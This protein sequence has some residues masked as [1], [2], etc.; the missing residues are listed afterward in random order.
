MERLHARTEQSLRE[1]FDCIREENGMLFARA[2]LKKL[3]GIGVGHPLAAFPALSVSIGRDGEAI[4][5]EYRAPM[6]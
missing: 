4:R 3:V 2:S 1:R 5:F 6:A